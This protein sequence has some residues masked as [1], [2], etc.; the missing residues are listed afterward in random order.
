MPS[1]CSAG[2]IHRAELWRP[3]TTGIAGFR[4]ILSRRKPQVAD[5]CRFGATARYAYFQRLAFNVGALMPDG[6]DCRQA[7][8]RPRNQYPLPTASNV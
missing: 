1:C 4:L 6:D 7:A 5:E 8:G 2:F 3:A